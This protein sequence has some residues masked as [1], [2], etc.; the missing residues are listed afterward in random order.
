MKV[1]DLFKSL[2]TIKKSVL[3][4]QQFFAIDFLPHLQGWASGLNR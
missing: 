4:L 1:S 2:L 3:S